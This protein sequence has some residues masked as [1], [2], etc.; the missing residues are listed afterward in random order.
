MEHINALH[1]LYG[2]LTKEL[3]AMRTEIWE[4]VSELFY[5]EKELY[6]AEVMAA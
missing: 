5:K 6:L 4:S 3:Y 2:Y 1:E